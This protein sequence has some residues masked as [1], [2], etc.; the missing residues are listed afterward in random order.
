MAGLIGY[1]LEQMCRQAV[2]E[3]ASGYS[4]NYEYSRNIKIGTKGRFP[5]I[6]D[7]DSYNSGIRR[8]C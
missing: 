3:P 5:F 6:R 7:D 8:S 1:E 4:R 2:M